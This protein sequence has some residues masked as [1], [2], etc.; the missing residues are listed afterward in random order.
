MNV[1]NI[2]ETMATARMTLLTAA[3]DRVIAGEI[4]VLNPILKALILAYIGRQFFLVM[5]GHMSIDRFMGS[6]IRA[7]VIVLLVTQSGQFVQYIR[8]PLFNKIPQAIASATLGGGAAAAT[9][10]IPRQFDST[11]AAADAMTASILAQS[12]AWSVGS[13]TNAFAA[14]LGNGGIQ[15]LL[16][17]TFGI[18]LIGQTNIAI[19]LCFGPPLLLFELFERTRGFVDQWIGKLV[20]MTAFGLATGV[21]MAIDLQGLVTMTQNAAAGATVSGAEG[22]SQIIHIASNILLDLL[23][24]AVLPMLVGFGSGV[25]AAFTVP[26]AFAAARLATGIG[27]AAA[28]GGG[29][30]GS[31]PALSRGNRVSGS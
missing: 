29:K 18:Y 17:A 9:T 22:V 12:T 24:M 13:I 31:S 26:S 15:F 10:T 30:P 23:A 21:L 8:D 5:L 1:S 19:V 3:M 27:R 6:I 7:G 2:F 25:A 28:G 14:S 4:A 20:G 16:A 11:S